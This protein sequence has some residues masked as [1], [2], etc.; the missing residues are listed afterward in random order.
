MLGMAMTAQTIYLCLR[1]Q[2][3][4]LTLFLSE[5]AI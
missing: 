5:H 1:M 3:F 2:I 4:K